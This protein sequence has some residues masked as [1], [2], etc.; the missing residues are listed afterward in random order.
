MRVFARLYQH[1][2]Q[3]WFAAESV[4]RA[5]LQLRSLARRLPRVTVGNT[6]QPPADADTALILVERPAVIVNVIVIVSLWSH[7][8]YI[9]RLETFEELEAASA[10]A[11]ATG[12]CRAGADGTRLW[13]QQR[14]PLPNVRVRLASLFQLAYEASH[15]PHITRDFSDI[16]FSASWI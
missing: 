6:G 7:F 4:E 14:D 5:P 1:D 10:L 9:A 11:C 12:S 8:R 15:M 16:T 3:E 2:L 13:R